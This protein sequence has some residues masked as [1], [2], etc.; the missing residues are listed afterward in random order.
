MRTESLWFRHVLAIPW[1]RSAVFRL[2][3]SLECCFN[4]GE[5][6]Y[7]YSKICLGYTLLQHRAKQG[8]FPAREIVVL[9]MTTFTDACVFSG[10]GPPLNGN[11]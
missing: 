5:S 9:E 10:V 6:I 11:L 1:S 2:N 3:T 7:M 8:D 4:L